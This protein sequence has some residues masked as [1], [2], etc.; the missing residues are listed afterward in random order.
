MEKPTEPIDQSEQEILS[1]IKEMV[2]FIVRYK[3]GPK[4]EDWK[5]LANEVLLAALSSLRE[6][7]FD[8]GKGTP[9]RTYVLGITYK[10]IGAYF[11]GAKKQKD[12]EA[13]VRSKHNFFDD[14]QSRLERD[15]YRHA[16]EQ[17]LKSLPDRY[18][19]VLHLK[20]FDE[21]SVEE[22]GQQLGI[23]P[24]RVSERIYYGLKLL[25]KKYKKKEK[26]FSILFF[27]LT[28]VYWTCFWGGLF[29]E[30]PL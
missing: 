18:A 29:N 17:I 8:P 6:D 7:R 10:K 3:L 14:E 23:P 1:S 16:I 27:I 26:I 12:M 5:D 9:F 4:N 2:Q 24:G 13:Q 28:I 22:I 21:I 11:K 25:R 19:V 20:F 15:E 30:M